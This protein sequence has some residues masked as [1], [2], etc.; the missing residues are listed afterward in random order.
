M[1]RRISPEIAEILWAAG[2]PGKMGLVLLWE[3]PRRCTAV[4]VVAVA[5]AAV[6][7][8]AWSRWLYNRRDGRTVDDTDWDRRRCRE[9]TRCSLNRR[10]RPVEKFNER[11]MHIREKERKFTYR[12]VKI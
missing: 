12:D 10:V 1:Q 4:V 6:A 3:R 7:V 11:G 8:F 2:R 9:R 5:A